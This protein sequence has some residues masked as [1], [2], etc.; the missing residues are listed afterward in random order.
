[1]RHPLTT[2]KIVA[3]FWETS[4]ESCGFK[5]F[6]IFNTNIYVQ[7]VVNDTIAR[8]VLNKKVAL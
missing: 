7:P 3:S 1:M 5:S 6:F 4:Y 2:F 8:F